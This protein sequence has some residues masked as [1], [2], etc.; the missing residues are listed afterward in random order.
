MPDCDEDLH[1]WMLCL[2]CYR[3]A[4]YSLGGGQGDKALLI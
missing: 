3:H 2:I 4:T 1:S